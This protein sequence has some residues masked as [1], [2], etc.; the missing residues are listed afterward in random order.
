VTKREKAKQA[1][2]VPRVGRSA[3]KTFGHIVLILLTGA[4]VRLIYDASLPDNIFLGNYT[5]DS[6][7]LQSLKS[8]NVCNLALRNRQ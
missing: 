1:S 7:A 4:V 6:L 3:N 8:D 5:L 2:K